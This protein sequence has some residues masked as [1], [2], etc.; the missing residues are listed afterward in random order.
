MKNHLR[1]Q[2]VAKKIQQLAKRNQPTL[3]LLLVTPTKLFVAFPHIKTTNKLE[4]TLFHY[5][6]RN[7]FF[8]LRSH[9]WCE[10]YPYCTIV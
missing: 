7:G 1:L 5:S 4:K 9:H 10:L 6:R 3:L 8:K 2:S